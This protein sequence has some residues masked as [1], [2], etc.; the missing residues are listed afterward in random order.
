LKKYP[1]QS[2]KGLGLPIYEIKP[3]EKYSIISGFFALMMAN[4]ACFIEQCAAFHSEMPHTILHE[5][6]PIYMKGDP[7]P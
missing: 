1:E 6:I 4:R 2:E 5:Q 3:L 7:K